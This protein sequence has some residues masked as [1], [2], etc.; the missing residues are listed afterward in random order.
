MI[1]APTIVNANAL[2]A[3]RH[4]IDGQIY[5]RDDRV[6]NDQLKALS[7]YQATWS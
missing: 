6:S 5:G 4:A 3:N 7:D 1:S 2:V